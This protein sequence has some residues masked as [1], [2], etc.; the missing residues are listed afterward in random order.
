M[1]GF[2]GTTCFLS[3]WLSNT[4]TAAMVIPIAHAVVTQM[5]ENRKLRFPDEGD[6]YENLGIGLR[7]SIAMAA[8]IGGIGTLTGTGPN[9]VLKENV[10][11]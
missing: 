11:T 1:F 9:L 2:M 8:N 7:I 5:T 10:D 3:M 4:A 6:I